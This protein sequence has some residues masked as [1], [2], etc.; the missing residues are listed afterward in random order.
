GEP[1]LSHVVRGTV[2]GTPVYL[3]PRADGQLIAGASSEETGFDMSARA[4]AVYEL[5]RDAQSMLPELAEAVL[6]EVCTGLRPGSPDN[7]PIIG[8]SGLSGLVHATGHFRNGIL[9]TAVTA[10]GVAELITTGEL[11]EALRP[12]APARFAQAVP[13]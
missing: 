5:L 10:D 3:V 6:E 11:P 2:K 8:S 13:A 12:F 1:R 7:A 9:L 4:G